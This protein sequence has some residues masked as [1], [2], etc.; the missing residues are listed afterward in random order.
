MSLSRCAKLSASTIENVASVAVAAHP[1]IEVAPRIETTADGKGLEVSVT[2]RNRG[3]RKADFKVYLNRGAGTRT[4]D[5]VVYALEPGQERIVRFLV[6]PDEKG[7]EYLVGL[8]GIED[9]L[10]V[11]E[12]VKVP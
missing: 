2:V 7:K 10:F 8:R 6:E 9:D 3:E 11:N 4:L 5:D 1:E 12:A